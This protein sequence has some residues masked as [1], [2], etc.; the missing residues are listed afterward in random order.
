MVKR[1]GEMWC[2]QASTNTASDMRIKNSI[3]DGALGLDF[4]KKLR[5]VSYKM[6]DTVNCD[7]GTG[8]ET[9]CNGVGPANHSG[10]GEVGVLR[11]KRPH[12]VLDLPRQ[13]AVSEW[14][15]S[16]GAP[17]WRASRHGRQGGV[18]HGTVV[19]SHNITGGLTVD[20]HERFY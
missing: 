14:T 15:R 16:N 17:Q 18:R 19:R 12:H 4:I 2:T 1:W 5:P 20:C 7:K 6:N 13:L 3:Q 10:N 9:G 11:D 8:K